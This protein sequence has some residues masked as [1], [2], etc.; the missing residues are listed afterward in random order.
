MRVRV[1]GLFLHGRCGF[2]LLGP[3]VTAAPQ[4]RRTRTVWF[5]GPLLPLPESQQAE[6]YPQDVAGEV[7]IAADAAPG[8]RRGR[9]W[10]SEGAASGLTFVV[11][12]LPEV[13]EE[14]IDGDPVPA[15]VTLPV[16]V[17]GRIFPREDVD[18]WAFAARKG[19]A[20]TAG[21]V[22]ARLGSPLDS[23]L[24]VRG[25]DG[26]VIAENDDALGADSL[27]HFTADRDGKYQVRVHDA[28]RRGGQNY[29]YRLTLTAGPYIDRVYPLGGRR[30][31]KVRFELRGHGLSGG[32]A[33]LTLPADAPAAYDARFSV[34]GTPSNPVRLGVDDLPEHL[35]S[36]PN[37]EAAQA[38]RVTLPAVVNGRVDRPGDVDCWAFAARKGEAIS[39][40]LR[41][42]QLGSPLQGVLTV[43]DGAGKQLAR[44]E[45]VGADPALT[46]TAPA[47]G[48]Y[49][50]RV[51]DRFRSRGGPDFAYRLRLAPAPAPGF[52]LRL[53][54][55]ALTLPR[56]K[57][58][59]LKV[60]VERVGGFSGPITLTLDGL[61][62]GVQ[63]ANATIGAGQPAV[64]VRLTA[65]PSAAIGPSR[66]RVRG[67]ASVGGRTVT[68]LATTP[69]AD[70]VLLGVALPAPFKV[71]GAYDL[72]LAPRGGVF[73]RRYKVERGGYDGPLEI[74]LA[75][76]QARHLQGVTA[77]AVVVPPGQN[78]F[79]FA[80]H[81][82][83]WAETGRTSRSCVMAIGVIKDGAAEHTVSY[84]SAAQND[85]VIA[86][87]ESGRLGLE[88]GV[89]S[90][91]AAP[92]A[93][94]NV[95]V[96]VSRAKDLA[97]PVRV[98][99]VLPGHVRGLS[100]AP[101]VIP[102]GRSG[103]T[104]TLRFGAGTIGSFNMP[105]VLRATLDTPGGPVVAEAKLE[106]VPQ[107]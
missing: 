8:P 92:G 44:A 55:D 25:P 29:V 12:E 78:E 99:L 70:S 73:H 49:V 1:G 102:A 39:L 107:P 62:A 36:E 74:R 83:P 69:E 98:E 47:D 14:E 28:N 85:Q 7:R 103:A 106:V 87:V 95:P 71:V 56:G 5:E 76:R 27:V 91:A 52:R 90:L 53:A 72:R 79:E 64:E 15:D 66:L 80:V 97:G 58:A 86:V 18:V 84:T 24:E 65:G 81:L 104:L 105:V 31:S 42:R 21:V 9:V 17:N 100:A 30:G 57:E 3:G 68:R 11:G 82:P 63:A 101:V 46:W 54:A 48:N 6:D 10:T 51:A 41:A 61:P 38:K 93:S 45:A 4:L 35:E 13:V 88:A 16:T 96:K 2:E 77:P 23:R 37:D 67:T 40:E 43:H 94:V 50:V 26:R 32:P 89:G 34:G 33:E 59:K 20:I 19:Q 75:D 60:S 22:A